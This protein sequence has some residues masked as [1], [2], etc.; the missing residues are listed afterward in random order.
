MAAERAEYTAVRRTALEILVAAEGARRFVDDLFGERSRAFE[1][2]DRRLLQ[3]LVYGSVRHQNTLDRIADFH[4]KTPAAEQRPPLRWALR[5]G[6]F[7]LVYLG[8]IPA[9]A[10]LHQTLE[11]LKSLPGVGPK[12]VGFVNAV[13]HNV[14]LDI[15]SKTQEP[16]ADR[17]DPTVLPARLGWCR[18]HRQVLPPYRAGAAAHLAVKH[19]HPEWLLRRWLARH[20]E[21]ETRALCEAQNRIPS[22]TARVTRL[23]PS[24]ETVLE[25]LRTEGFEVE[26]A[27]HDGAFIFRRGGDFDRSPTF[28][29]GWFQIQDET[30]MRI[31]AVLSP[32]R[33]A[34]VLD[35]CSSPGGKALQLLEAVG[36]EGRLVAA[37]RSEEKLEPVRRTLARAGSNFTARVVPEEPAAIDLGETFTHIL[38]DAPCS[39]TGVL[40]RRP[41]ARWRLRP[42]DLGILPAL[43]LALLEAALR[44]LEPGGRL[45]YATCSIEPEEN[46]DTAAR[47]VAAHPELVELETRLFLPH[48]TSGDG[49]FF[50]LLRR[51]VQ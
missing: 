22:V 39:N 43:Q 50:S 44:H 41:E 25:A 45:L 11:A 3:E 7:Q 40:A 6:A 13:L 2:R 21:E 48:R 5:L 32:P 8:R 23:A 49:G 20:G 28:A 4:L 36:A 33:G 9:H 27:R 30:A 15:R 24:R 18:F 42:E 17:D 14:L 46:E 26:P 51:A 1:A 31:G 37:D 10:A 19:S 38:V 35:L 16:P 12:N 29:S 34:R 47:L